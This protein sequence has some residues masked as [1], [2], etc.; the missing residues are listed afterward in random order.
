MKAITETEMESSVDVAA[1][2]IG[3]IAICAEVPNNLPWLI[4]AYRRVETMLNDPRLTN[5]VISVGPIKLVRDA[6]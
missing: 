5:P 1:D 3:E 4:G 6:P 2:L